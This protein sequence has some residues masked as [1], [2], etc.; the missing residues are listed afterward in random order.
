M[1]FRNLHKNEQIILEIANDLYRATDPQRASDS[2][3]ERLGAELHAE[4][5]YIFSAHNSL[6]DNTYEWCA[7]GVA[8]E[9]GNLQGI[10][11]ANFSRWLDLFGRNECVLIEDLSLLKGTIDDFEY[12]TLAQQGSSPL[13]VSPIERDG[14]LVGFLGL[15]NPP[16]ELIRDIAPLLRTLCYF[17]SR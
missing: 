15:D 2:M 5:A 11:Y 9:I 6:F 14:E 7:E 13:V 1:R 8:P 4:R 16:V 17:Y 3:L 12:E 10:D